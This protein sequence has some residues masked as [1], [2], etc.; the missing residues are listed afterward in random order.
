MSVPRPL[1]LWWINPVFANWYTGTLWQG[2][3]SETNK[4]EEEIIYHSLHRQN[5]GTATK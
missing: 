4:L 3:A 2:I 1:Y 5:V